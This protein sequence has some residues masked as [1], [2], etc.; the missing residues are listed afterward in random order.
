MLATVTE[1]RLGTRANVAQQSRNTPDH[2]VA[3]AIWF[4]L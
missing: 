4:P 1:V 3:A 2:N